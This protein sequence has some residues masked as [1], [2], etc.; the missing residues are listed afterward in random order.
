MCRNDIGDQWRKLVHDL[1]GP[2][3]FDIWT[4]AELDEG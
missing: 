3:S 2:T 4:R 1:H